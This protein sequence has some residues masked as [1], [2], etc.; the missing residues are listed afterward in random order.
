MLFTVG[1][2]DL[3]GLCTNENNYYTRPIYVKEAL[4]LLSNDY[5]VLSSGLH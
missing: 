4:L 1:N 5:S 3:D 2:T